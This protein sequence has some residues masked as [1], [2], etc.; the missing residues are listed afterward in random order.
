M[1]QY[2]RKEMDTLVF[3]KK[4]SFLLLGLKIVG[5]LFFL[6]CSLLQAEISF[7]YASEHASLPISSSSETTV[8]KEEAGSFPDSL[9]RRCIFWTA[10]LT[11][12]LS[13]GGGLLSY[14]FYRH[15]QKEHRRLTLH[16]DLFRLISESARI[17]LE[18]RE[19]SPGF[20]KICRHLHKEMHAREVLMFQNMSSEKELPFPRLAASSLKKGN[21][22]SLPLLFSY[23]MVPH[24]SDT[25][26]QGHSRLV[27]A[28][29]LPRNMQETEKESPLPPEGTFF[30][31]PIQVKKR[32]WGSLVLVSEKS[33]PP[34]SDQSHARFWEI[35][36]EIFGLHL[37][38]REAEEE[39]REMATTDFLT[40]TWNRRN[41]ID[42]A[43]REILRSQRHGH[44]LAMILFDIDNFKDINDAFGHPVGDHVLQELSALA[45]KGFRREDMIGRLG[46]EEFGIIL[47]ETSLSLAESVAE[48]FR[49]LVEQHDMAPSQGTKEPIHITI[50]CG[51]ALLHEEDS[52]YELYQRA[53]EAL[54]RAKKQGKNRICTEEDCSLS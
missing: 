11:L 25:L 38:R 21:T 33:A 45:L 46:G 49:F 4:N 53:D 42:S 44:S 48:R 51:I 1:E 36:S 15:H 23:D 24:L 14:L 30:F 34:W 2:Q 52:F 28:L 31:L 22:H 17:L 6:S 20:R 41:F 16:R 19:L 27:P 32:W 29:S 18:E 37:M 26:R 40:G 9:L 35:F 7:S 54:Y 8:E 47:P 10:L 39:L 43:E 5:A 50:T 12:V 13:W 3:R